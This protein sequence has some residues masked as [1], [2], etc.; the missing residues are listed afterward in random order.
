MGRSRSGF[1]G[2]SF[3]PPGSLSEQF[4]VDGTNSGSPITAAPFNSSLNTTTLSDGW[5]TIGATV[6]NNSAKT[7]V[8]PSRVVKVQNGAAG[9]SIALRNQLG[10]ANNTNTTDRIT[11][12]ITAAAPVGDTVIVAAGQGS[13]ALTSVTDSRGN[14]YAIDRPTVSNGSGAFGGVAI[15]ST[16]ITT[17]LQSGD[18]ITAIFAASASATRA[19]AA[20]DFSGVLTQSPWLDATASAIGHNNSPSSGASGATQAAP[21]LVIGA[22]G[23]TGTSATTFTPTS[24]FQS[25]GSSVG[26]LA[27][28][29]LTYKIVATTGAQ[30]ASGTYSGRVSPYWAVTLATYKPAPTDTTPPTAPGSPA[31]TT[32]PGTVNLTWTASSD[33]GGVAYYHV[34]RSTTSGFTPG[35]GNEIG[36][37]TLLTYTDNGD[38]TTNGL[39]AATYYYKLIAQDQAGNLSAASTQ[40]SQSVTA[41]SALPK[42]NLTAPTTGQQV[43]GTITVS[44]NATDA[45]G[46]ASTVSYGFDAN[47][48]R[49]SRTLNG[50]TTRYLLGG[51][52][53][54]T[55]AG[56]I[57]VFDVDGPAG[58]LAH[59][60]QPPTAGVNPS[61][62]YYSGHGDL[63]A[64]ADNTGTRTNTYRYD[65]FGELT[66]LPTTTNPIERYT[67]AWDKKL[68]P[69]AD[70][71]EMGARPYDANIGRFYAIDPVNGGSLNNYD[72]AGQDPINGYDLSGTMLSPVNEGGGGCSVRCLAGTGTPGEPKGEPDPEDAE[73]IVQGKTTRGRARAAV[74]GFVREVENF[75]GADVSTVRALIDRYA[76]KAGWQHAGTASGERWF[77]SREGYQLRISVAHGDI[78]LYSQLLNSS[79][80]GALLGRANLTGV[81]SP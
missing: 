15:A 48:F 34:Y 37:T 66:T 44:A 63:V 65:P 45:V 71:I 20:A 39:P 1:S 57:T 41:N 61:Y 21:E 19:I 23:D 36:Q 50:T 47:G 29:R 64:E 75:E 27:S 32:T 2:G 16:R 30:T 6:T 12:T 3:T 73:S 58:D 68:D 42:T 35:A 10:N 40:A 28:L 80:P 60:T 33:S 24:P 53:E 49:R 55:T 72:Y 22:Y 7:G 8:A 81:Y 13:T 46:I 17:A 79:G 52:V 25:A 62:L 14:S 67:G 69:I 26:T 70:L 76:R 18:T 4:T 9:S 74:L 11:L 43:S 38:G 54:T 31:A 56:T 59:Y 77:S 78:R 5:H 51:L